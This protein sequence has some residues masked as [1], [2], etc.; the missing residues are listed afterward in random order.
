MPE[1]GLL[2]A[3]LARYV[4]WYTL[5]QV[6][7]VAT[8]TAVAASGVTL[9]TGNSLIGVVVVG[10]LVAGL[11]VWHEKR[12]PTAKEKHQLALLCMLV[13][14]LVSVAAICAILAVSGSAADVAYFKRVLAVSPWL[15]VAITIGGSAFIYI[16][17]LFC[18]GTF[19]QKLAHRGCNTAR[20]SAN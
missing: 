11:F 15:L 8:A 20:P 17:L 18:F 14:W 5:G 16:A 7:D 1:P 10:I 4:G 9:K 19:A 13:T 6:L 2:P 12:A 3:R